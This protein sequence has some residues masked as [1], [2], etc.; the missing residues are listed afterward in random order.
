MTLACSDCAAP[1]TRQS[2]T[3]RCRVCAMRACAK[4]PSRLAKMSEAMKRKW[5]DPEHRRKC[6]QAISAARRVKVATDPA[7]AELMR[8]KGR[9]LAATRLGAECIRSGKPARKKIAASLSKHYMGWCPPDRREEYRK[10]RRNKRL[11]G[12]EA[13]RIILASLTPFERQMQAIRNGAA[14]VAKPTIRAR[15]YDYTLGGVS[16]MA[17]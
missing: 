13:K 8:E 10:L 3:G 2:K 14:L 7:F 1:I 4:D 17:A 16:D 15:D 12:A 5:A 6:S 9:I 11:P